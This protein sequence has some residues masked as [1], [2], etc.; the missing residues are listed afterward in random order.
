MANSVIIQQE[1]LQSLIEEHRLLRLERL[2]LL[3]E[4]KL[5]LQILNNLKEQ[6]KSLIQRN[7]LLQAE[8]KAEATKLLSI[9]NIN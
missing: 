3:A 7:R 1:E 2:I 9:L 5:H 6:R 4:R 8:R